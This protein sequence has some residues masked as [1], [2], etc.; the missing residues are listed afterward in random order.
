MSPTSVLHILAP[1]REGGLERVVAMLAAGQQD[2]GVHVAAVL[3]PGS[4]SAHPFV[5]RL[6][7]L[8]IPTTQIV[9]GAR[10][11]YREYRI[12]ATLIERLK[13]AVVHTHGYRA[14]V[15]GSSAA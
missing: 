3:Q 6:Q 11:Y 7:T 13:P 5:S 12:L 4:H 9:V 10:G 2:L 15:V 1:A 8:G 14:D